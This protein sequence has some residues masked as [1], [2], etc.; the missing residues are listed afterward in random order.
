MSEMRKPVVSQYEA[1]H[2]GRGVQTLTICLVKVL[3]SPGPDCTSSS[4]SLIQ[5]HAHTHLLA[6][7]TSEDV[8]C[9]NR[10]NLALAGKDFLLACHIACFN[11]E[12]LITFYHSDMVKVHLN[13]VAGFD[14]TS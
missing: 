1:F 6:A 13:A 3:I 4:R 10:L 12:D 9:L 11:L 14:H 8:G 7:L 2:N 5:I